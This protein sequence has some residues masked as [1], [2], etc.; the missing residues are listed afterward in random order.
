MFLGVIIL[1]SEIFTFPDLFYNLN[2]VYFHLFML[3]WL[4][5][6]VFGVAWWLFP[7]LPKDKNNSKKELYKGN[8]KLAYS[9]YFSLNS[10]LVLRAFFEPY[11]TLFHDLLSSNLL[12]ISAILQIYSAFC[13]VFLLWRRVY[14]RET[15]KK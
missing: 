4:N 13:F 15:S 10:G 14:V 5:Q 6:L 11:N 3:G 9:L 8:E 7:L 2:P 12:I 1:L